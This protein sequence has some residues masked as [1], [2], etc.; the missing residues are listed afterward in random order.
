ME[1]EFDAIIIGAGPA[2]STTAI[3]LARYGW[4]VALVEKQ[5]F[6]RRKVCGECIAATN[7]PLLEELGIGKEFSTHAG[8]ALRQIALMAGDRT[9]RADFPPYLDT[10][11][12]WGVALSREHLDTL[13]LAQALRC[14]VQLF[15][16][17]IARGI[18]GG[19]GCF[20]CRIS[21]AHSARN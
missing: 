3:L 19:P 5:C 12:R 9:I 18:D 11:H 20:H 16:P 4:R 1:T 10:C 13:L 21:E 2:G 7:L 17:W 14:G 15:Q 6:P 8:P